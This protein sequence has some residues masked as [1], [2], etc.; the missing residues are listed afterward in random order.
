MN[1]LKNSYFITSFKTYKADYYFDSRHYALTLKAL[2][3]MY[4]T[5]YE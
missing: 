4:F 2:S 1:P 3:H 5:I